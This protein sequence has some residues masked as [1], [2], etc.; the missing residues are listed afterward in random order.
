MLIILVKCRLIIGDEDKTKAVNCTF[1]REAIWVWEFVTLI[2]PSVE[3]TLVFFKPLHK[4]FSIFYDVLMF[5]T[6]NVQYIMGCRFLMRPIL[7]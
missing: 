3:V 7:Q 1:H 4:T 5:M 2:I 6:I